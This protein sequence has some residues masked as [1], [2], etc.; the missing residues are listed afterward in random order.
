MSHATFYMFIFS[1]L[2][3]DKGKPPSTKK[4][5]SDV[6]SFHIRLP[7]ELFCDVS[8]HRIDNYVVL[9]S[10]FI[11]VLKTKLNYRHVYILDIYYQETF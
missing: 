7:L 10:N 11:S 6:S 5:D 1:L 2:Q 9:E 4:Q 3:A 8:W